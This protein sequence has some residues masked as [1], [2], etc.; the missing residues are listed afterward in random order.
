LKIEG[1]FW[2]DPR[3]PQSPA[4]ENTAFSCFYRLD[5]GGAP[6]V[7][8][9]GFPDNGYLAGGSRRAPAERF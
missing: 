2:V 6:F 7:N 9:D 4:V 8:V 1:M 3:D 5:D